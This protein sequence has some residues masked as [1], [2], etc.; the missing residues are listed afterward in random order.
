MHTLQLHPFTV[1]CNTTRAAAFFTFSPYF[2]AR[3]TATQEIDFPRF[4][5][6]DSRRKENI[7]R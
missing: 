3:F 1:P 6:I 2:T 7:F 4:A 5:A